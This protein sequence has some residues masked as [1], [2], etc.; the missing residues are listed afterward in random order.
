MFAAWAGST[1]TQT[2]QL[3]KPFDKANAEPF[4]HLP[5]SA[6]LAKLGCEET[7]DCHGGDAQLDSRTDD[8]WPALSVP[9]AIVAE[10]GGEGP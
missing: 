1:R 10:I 6:A 4:R 9:I 7:S 8:L 2:T 3:D 5:H